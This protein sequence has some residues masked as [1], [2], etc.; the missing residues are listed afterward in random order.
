[1]DFSDIASRL[2]WTRGVRVLRCDGNGLMAIEKPEGTL[3]HPNRKGDR[4]RSLLNANYEEEAERYEIVDEEGQVERHVY[5]LNRLDSAT[6]GIVLLAL[7][8]AVA[9]AVLLAFERKQV[10]KTYCA[11]VFGIPRRGSPIW[12][13]RLSVRKA[14]G[15][16]RAS[17]GSGLQAET[18]LVKAESLPGM[19]LMSRLTLMPVTGRT[20]QLRIQSSK[21]GLPIV[22]DRT[23]GDFKRNKLVAK[24]KQIKRL[25]LHCVGTELSYTHAG[26]LHRFKASSE[27][28]F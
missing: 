23:Y 11:L 2:P 8:E 24:S 3:S 19:P 18:K 25:C 14:E 6:S 20:H 27:A 5:L 12:K 7:D 13:D 1:M 15:G 9:S 21:R 16:V 10:R 4:S 26:G 22:G 17:S 28:P